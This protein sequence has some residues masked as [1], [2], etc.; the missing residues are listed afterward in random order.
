MGAR[1]STRRSTIASGEP[2]SF[3]LKKNLQETHRQREEGDK[4]ARPPVLSVRSLTEAAPRKSASRC[5][6]DTRRTRSDVNVVG[7]SERAQ[8]GKKDARPP[9]GR[10]SEPEVAS[11]I[12]SQMIGFKMGPVLLRNGE[13]VQGEPT[14]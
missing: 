9:R 13:Y 12:V 5:Q 14:R 10:A 3:R 1:N 4:D 11:R 7:P 6:T 2:G 8:R